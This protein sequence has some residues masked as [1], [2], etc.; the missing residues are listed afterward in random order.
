MIFPAGAVSE[1]LQRD[2]AYGSSY[3]H[4]FFNPLYPFVVSVLVLVLVREIEIVLACLSQTQFSSLSA[5]LDLLTFPTLVSLTGLFDV[6][7]SCSLNTVMTPL[8]F[9]IPN[10][11]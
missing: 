9:F 3:F 5:A 6:Y 8:A 1:S 2:H 4:P 11:L 10:I 7:C